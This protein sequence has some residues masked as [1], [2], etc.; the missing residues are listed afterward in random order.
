MRRHPC[1]HC[2]DTQASYA[3]TPTPT[4]CPRSSIG[5]RHHGAREHEYHHAVGRHYFQKFG[6]HLDWACGL[7]PRSRGALEA[8]YRGDA[9]VAAG[10]RHCPAR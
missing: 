5:L 2:T 1:A 3:L 9:E 10:A 6:T 4:P 8:F 7:L